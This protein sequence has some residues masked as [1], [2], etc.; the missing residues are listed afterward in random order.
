M[1]EDAVYV[2]DLLFSPFI[3]IAK[4]DVSF[5]F[6]TDR[7]VTLQDRCLCRCYHFH[8]FSRS[9]RIKSVALYIYFKNA[10]GWFIESR[11]ISLNKYMDSVWVESVS[12]CEWNDNRMIFKWLRERAQFPFI[13]PSI[14]SIT[15]YFPWKILRAN[16]SSFRLTETTVDQIEHFFTTQKHTHNFTSLPLYQVFFAYIFHLV[17]SSFLLSFQKFPQQ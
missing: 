17:R 8:I 12:M 3:S 4:F 13:K 7:N 10:S 11:K 15:S 9:N 5:S 2:F 6:Q 14:F 1:N 16:E